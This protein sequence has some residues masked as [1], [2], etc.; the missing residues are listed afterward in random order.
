VRNIYMEGGGTAI[1]ALRARGVQFWQCNIALTNQAQRIAAAMN[2]PPAEVR[3]DLIAGLN[4]GVHLVP[5][6]V[7]ALCLVQERGFAYVKV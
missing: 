3:A 7:M 1:T 6:H 5:A 4:P 2:L